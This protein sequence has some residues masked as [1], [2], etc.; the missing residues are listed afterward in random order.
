MAGKNTHNTHQASELKA[1]RKRIAEL[2]DEIK[3]SKLSQAGEQPADAEKRSWSGDYLYSLL[4]SIPDLIWLKDPNGVFLTCNSTFEK[5][6]GAQESEIVG[7]TDYDFVSEELADFFRANDLKAM[8]SDKPSI[9]EEWLTFSEDG[10]RGLFETIKTPMRD[11]DGRLIGVLGIARDITDRKRTEAQLIE[12]KDKAETASKVKSEFLA[13]MSHEIRTPLNGALAMLQLLQTTSLSGQQSEYLQAVKTSLHRLNRLL[14]DILDIARIEA[15]K[16]K[17]ESAE[18]QVKNLEKAILELFNQAAKARGNTLE[19]VWSGKFPEIIIGD[20]ARLRQI[21]FNLVG[22]AVKFT[23]DG[24]ITIEVS[25]WPCSDSS[26]IYMHIA[27]S[28]TGIGITDEQINDVV[29][30]FVQAEEK[31]TRRFQGVGLGLSIVR[32][33]VHLMHGELAIDNGNKAG[34]VMYISLPFTVTAKGH[35]EARQA[36]ESVATE[37]I[38]NLKIL[39]AE[40]EGISSFAAKMLLEKSG[41]AVTCVQNGLEVIQLLSTEDFDLIF[42]DIQ[43]PLMDGVEA[44]RKIRSSKELGRKSEIPIIAMTAYSMIGD[45]ENFLAAGMN[46]YVAKPI[47]MKEI[48]EV[49]VRLQTPLQHDSDTG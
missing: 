2:E 8:K 42:M 49:L 41:H 47:S 33:L 26:R 40:D 27:V 46:D 10:Y 36:S 3:T 24:R 16:L 5:F 29:E 4:R 31:Y 28:D 13:N 18:F 20:E 34:T 48:N 9:N 11:R 15:G 37:Q 30:P 6:F 32:K 35:I 14:A 44:T 38:R 25:F 12:M 43:M 1:L 21:L 17:I 45:R 23:E 39:L 7:K 22:N 19:F